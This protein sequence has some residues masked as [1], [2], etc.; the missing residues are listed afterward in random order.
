MGC[1]TLELWELFIAKRNIFRSSKSKFEL[2]EA[3]KSFETSG[4]ISDKT[5]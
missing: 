3:R 4:P 2:F 5:H 1:R